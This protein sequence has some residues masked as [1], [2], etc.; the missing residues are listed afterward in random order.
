MKR[1]EFLALVLASV[2]FLKAN[3]TAEEIAKLGPVTHPNHTE[4]CILGQMTGHYDS[5]RAKEISEKILYTDHKKGLE[6]VNEKKL[7]LQVNPFT[8]FGNSP[9]FTENCLEIFSL[10]PIENETPIAAFEKFICMDGAN[11]A[12]L[13]AYIKGEAETFEP[14]FN[15]MVEAEA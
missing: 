13:V 9:R 15:T 6:L 2:N 14:T 7:Q 3:A 4:G 10:E 5:D 8:F 11:I 12:D 1:A